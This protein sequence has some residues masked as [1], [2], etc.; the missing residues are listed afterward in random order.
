MLLNIYSFIFKR[1]KLTLRVFHNTLKFRCLY[2]KYSEKT[3]HVL[4]GNTQKA[5]NSS[6]NQVIVH[7]QIHVWPP[8]Q[9]NIKALSEQWMM[10]AI[11]GIYHRELRHACCETPIVTGY[12]SH[13]TSR[14]IEI[15]AG[16]RKL[17]TPQRCE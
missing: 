13:E 7:S 6:K 3:W 17:F 2:L 14:K 1:K 10:I 12:V 16:E 15:T 4:S 11:L 5:S 8:W 9:E